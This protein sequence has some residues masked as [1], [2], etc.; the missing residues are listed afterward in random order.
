M[1]LLA[2]GGNLSVGGIR[3]YEKKKNGSLF[4]YEEQP[5]ETAITKNFTLT[6]QQAKINGKDVNTNVV[7]FNCTKW[8]EESFFSGEI[9]IDL[10][11]KP[12]ILKNPEKIGTYEGLYFYEIKGRKFSEKTLG[13]IAS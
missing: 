12:G 9:I 2:S 8:P 3:V 13:D 1:P 6:I 10:S 4:S 11:R 5:V 7:I